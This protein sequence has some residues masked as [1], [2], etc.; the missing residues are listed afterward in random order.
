MAQKTVNIVNI[1]KS[2]VSGNKHE[3]TIFESLWLKKEADLRKK[4]WVLA[5]QIESIV[6]EKVNDGLEMDTVVIEEAVVEE[7]VAETTDKS[8][9]EMTKTELQAVCTEKGIKFH[10]ANKKEKLIELLGA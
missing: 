7:V 1:Q 9:P 4:G 6:V 3:S 2:G 5:D 10:H 8:Y